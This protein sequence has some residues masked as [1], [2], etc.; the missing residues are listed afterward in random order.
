[1]KNKSN[2]IKKGFA[3]IDQAD[4]D[5]VNAVL[6]GKKEKFAI[7]YKRY[8][9]IILQKYSSRLKF[10]NDLAEDLTAEV[11]V[12][13]FEN[14]HKYQPHYTFNSW[15]TR[16]SNN[17]LIDYIRKQ[18]RKKNLE[19]V[20]MNT[21]FASDKM[22][23]DDIDFVFD[24]RDEDYAAPDDNLILGQRTEY[25]EKALSQLD[26]QYRVVVNKRF[27]EEKSYDEIAHEIGMTLGA[28]KSIIFRAKDKL[29]DIITSDK[30]ML[31]AVAF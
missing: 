13:V 19:T 12:R 11:F 9:A 24:V 1:M 30:V 10:N 22:K 6:A 20:S 31:V 16:V 7:I 26:E 5:A 15:I 29:K 25:M 17:F 4:I 21:G 28:V 8:Y 14:M 3:T 18:K 23:N 2:T 27:Y